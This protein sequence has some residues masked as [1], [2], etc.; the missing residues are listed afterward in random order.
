M[1]PTAIESYF[2][3]YS[4]L[5]SIKGG[6]CKSK[7]LAILVQGI[8]HEISTKRWNLDQR[9]I[10]GVMSIQNGTQLGIQ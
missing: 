2:K 6:V 7:K 10:Q 4:K 5:R 1:D 3:N 8:P 9:A